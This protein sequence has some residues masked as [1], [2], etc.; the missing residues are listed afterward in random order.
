VRNE[1]GGTGTGDDAVGPSNEVVEKKV[2]SSF[3]RRRS[4]NLRAFTSK[5]PGEMDVMVLPVI[6]H[7][8]ALRLFSEK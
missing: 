8:L 3:L 2:R 7:F 1:G 6:A 5:I 4:S